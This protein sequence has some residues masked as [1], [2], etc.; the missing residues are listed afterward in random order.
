MWLWK[1]VITHLIS[2][3]LNL[4]EWVRLHV[5]TRCPA[6]IVS[7]ELQG[8]LSY[9]SVRVFFFFFLSLTS[10]PAVSFSVESVVINRETDHHDP[11]S[12]CYYLKN[13]STE[14]PPISAR[15][16]THRIEQLLGEFAAGSA[17][18]VPVVRGCDI[19]PQGFSERLCIW[20]CVLG[21]VSVCGHERVIYSTETTPSLQVAAW[22]VVASSGASTD[23]VNVHRRVCVSE[24]L[25]SVLQPLRHCSLS[26]CGEWMSRRSRARV[27]WP[28]AH[29]RV[30]LGDPKTRPL[31]FWLGW[32]GLRRTIST[33]LK[34][35][36]MTSTVLSSLMWNYICEVEPTICTRDQGKQLKCIQ[37]QGVAQ[38][39]LF[40]SLSFSIISSLLLHWVISGL[41]T[42]YFPI[43]N[44]A[45]RQ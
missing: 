29:R 31:F 21:F 30:S 11:C 14:Y 20:M 1:V 2:V 7:A 18:L 44:Q 43:L 42:Q 27:S 19:W 10:N 9:S 33:C 3:C 6:D 13:S 35:C 17:L 26:P 36:E 5:C 38:R 39:V 28:F 4:R 23:C 16:Y 24:H 8:C 41:I 22:M 32:C 40:L 25:H 34:G 45:G 37:S 15:T 12:A